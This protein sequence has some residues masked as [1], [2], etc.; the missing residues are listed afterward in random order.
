MTDEQ[1]IEAFD[2]VRAAAN[3]KTTSLQQAMEAADSLVAR[4]QIKHDRKAVQN[5]ASKLSE[6]IIMGNQSEFD[7]LIAEFEG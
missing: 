4:G 6:F 7:K 2:R 1:K 3:A 5:T